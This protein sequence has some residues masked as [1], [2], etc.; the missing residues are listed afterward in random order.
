MSEVWPILYV[1]LLFGGAALNL[2]G[3]PGNWVMFGAALG[4]LLLVE[5]GTPAAIP[6]A[7]PMLLAFLALIGE[8]L[9]FAAGM[10]G[11]GKAGGSRR[12]MFL[13][14]IGSIV[15][16]LFG[17]SLGNLIVPILGGIVGLLFFAG[18]GALVGAMI[19]E[20]WK[21]RT[22]DDSLR[23]GKAAMLGRILGT[24]AKSL[25]GGLMLCVGLLG[26]LF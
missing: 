18:L 17:F 14:M 9:E 20:G 7:I 5:A 19:G 23:V 12:G 10:A 25:I 24:L 21:G 11:A 3:L 16:S 6:V 1:L 4:H 8:M 2:F 22:W 13:S 15:G 26:L